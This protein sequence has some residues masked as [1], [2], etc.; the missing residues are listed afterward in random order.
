[1]VISFQIF[2]GHSTPSPTVRLLG[3]VAAHPVEDK[4]AFVQGILGA[5]AIQNGARALEVR[6]MLIASF[7]VQRQPG[8]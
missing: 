2:V 8:N 6:M 3:L 5:Y 7:G 1:M 4:L